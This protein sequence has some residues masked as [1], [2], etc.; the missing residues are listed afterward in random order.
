MRE[1]MS[2]EDA[3]NV[4]RVT[5]DCLSPDVDQEVHDLAIAAKQLVHHVV[6]QS[7]ELER[8]RARRR[9]LAGA[10][11]RFVDG[12]CLEAGVDG[13]GR[14]DFLAGRPVHAGDGLYLLT[15]LGWHPVRYESN[16]PRQT[17]LLYM[18]LPG[19]ADEIVFTAPYTARLVWPDE[20][21]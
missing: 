7:L 16:M 8:E 20:L 19:A 17:S 18:P 6:Q 1:Q 11:R 9:A 13:G 12:H 21:R 3:I 4:V 5:S 14:R 15:C 2:V 10:D